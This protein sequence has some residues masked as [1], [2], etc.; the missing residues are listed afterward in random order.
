MDETRFLFKNDNNSIHN[1]CSKQFLIF[2][3]INT[4][5]TLP[6]NYKFELYCLNLICN[7]LYKY[8][9]LSI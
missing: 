7:Q 8:M 1:F 6:K 9:K 2:F 4:S 5:L 3:F